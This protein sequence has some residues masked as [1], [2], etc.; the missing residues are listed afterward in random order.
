MKSVI[1]VATTQF[2]HKPGDKKYNLMIIEKM[3][4]KA[5]AAG[6]KIISFPEMCITG[7]WHVRNLNEK[8]VKRLAEDPLNGPSVQKLKKLSVE[9]NIII[10]AGLIEES[11]DNQLYNTYVV[12]QPDRPTGFHRKLHC[13]ISEFMSS[14][15]KFTVIETSLGVKLGVLICWD[16]NLVE[17]ARM[18]ALGGAD[19]LLA[20][21]QTGGCKHRS[22]HVLGT[23]DISLWENRSKDL[24]SLKKEFSGI[25]GKLWLERW[26]PS[27]AH[28]NGFF[29]IFSNGVGQDDDEVRTGNAMLIDCFGEIIIQSDSIEDD[30]V[31]GE[32]D[33][34]LLEKSLG[35][36]WMKG[37]RPNLYCQLIEPVKNALNPINLKYRE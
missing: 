27:R 14:G 19:I 35:R 18:T 26:L 6:V 1:Q 31:L 24:E 7:Y 22:G 36:N 32:F 5:S 23:I 4:R 9:L 16:N 17:N 12:I 29:L 13:F 11:S 20:P 21:H 2:N 34:S 25:K 37:R 30:L 33:M 10:G 3:C 28:D 8:E 15:D